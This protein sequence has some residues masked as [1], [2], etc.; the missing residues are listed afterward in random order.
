ML[1]T[2][3]GS[4]HMSCSV[5]SDAVNLASRTEGLTKIY[6]AAL[7][8]SEYTHQ[9]LV[10]PDRYLMRLVD[11]VQVQ[12]MERPV[13]MYEVFDG[14]EEDERARKQRTL[15]TYHEALTHYRE[16]RFSAAHALIRQCLAIAPN[17][18]LLGLYE[19]RCVKLMRQPP[20][21][22]WQG[23]TRLDTKS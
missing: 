14:D 22:G 2:I 4:D 8:V 17:D 5:I 12:G 15:A 9:R 18:V 19:N 13:T 6:G 1:G 23:V 20:P 16:H 21:P 3:G 10:D 7:L 11:R